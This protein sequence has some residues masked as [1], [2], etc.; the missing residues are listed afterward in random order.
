M[1]GKVKSLINWDLEK[2]WTSWLCSE[3]VPRGI[4]EDKVPLGDEGVRKQNT[5]LWFSSFS[6]EK[7]FW[8]GMNKAKK[9]KLKTF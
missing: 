4:R 6:K 1:A 9:K 7:H 3:E 2:V 8:T 5:Q